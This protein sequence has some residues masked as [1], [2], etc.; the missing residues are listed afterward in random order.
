MFEQLFGSKT[1]AKLLSL[2]FNNPHRSFYVREI[3]RDI[4][5]QINS[6]RR[7]LANLSDLNIVKS[8]P[9]AG[10]L[11]YALNSKFKF[12]KEFKVVFKGAKTDIKTKDENKLA[13]DLK[14]T[15]SIH[16]AALMGYFTQ[17]P[18]NQIDLFLVGKIDKKKLKRILSSLE[19]EAGK[20]INFCMLSLEEYNQRN[21]LYD[22]FLTEVMT[23]PKIEL[24]NR[25]E[26]TEVY[27]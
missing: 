10:K 16:Y 2:F 27:E 19:K 18:N 15:G 26:K 24:I 17:D 13:T 22:R 4:D 8:H 14:R 9:K 7:E 25:L 3:T 6:V 12:V 20:E 1:R 23:S 21:L 5:E 11:Y